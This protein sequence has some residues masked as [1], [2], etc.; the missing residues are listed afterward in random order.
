MADKCKN[1]IRP[2]IL[3]KACLNKKF[4]TTREESKVHAREDRKLAQPVKPKMKLTPEKLK[5]IASQQGVQRRVEY[6][7]RGPIKKTDDTTIEDLVKAFERRDDYTLVDPREFYGAIQSVN[8][9]VLSWVTDITKGMDIGEMKETTLP[10]GAR[11]KVRKLANDMYSGHLIDK[12][13]SI[14]HL[15]DRL[16][17]PALAS[18]IMS[19]YEVYDE[20]TE[21]SDLLSLKAEIERLNKDIRDSKIKD[22]IERGEIEKRLTQVLDKIDHLEK[23]SNELE[24]DVKTVIEKEEN[25]VKKKLLTLKNRVE[26]DIESKLEVVTARKAGEPGECIDCNSSPCVCYT[27]LSRP[28]IDV[29]PDG[30]VNILFKSDWNSL[31]KTNFLK[32][33]KMVVDRKMKK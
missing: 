7:R 21:N 12:S 16:T 4:P 17:I 26:E 32:T 5:E 25:E 10:T 8:R 22:G 31:D 28:S 6:A 13:G 19:V 20:E 29:F 15:Y 30:R 33:M 18:Q 3:L 27:H 24:Q 14:D 23:L 1:I 11:I 2:L 9:K